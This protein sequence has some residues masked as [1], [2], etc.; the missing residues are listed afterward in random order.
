M[1]SPA[2]RPPSRETARP[3]APPGTPSN[4]I[5]SASVNG[6]A[7][8]SNGDLTCD[9]VSLED[10]AR[11]H[12]TPL[13]VYSAARIDEAY[14]R[15]DAAFAAGPAPRLLR[16]QGQLEPRD[17]PAARLAR[18]RGRR[19]LGRRAPGLPR[20]RLPGRRRSSSP[21]SAR[22]TRSCGSASRAG[23]SPST[24]SPSARS[25]ASTRWPRSHNRTARVALRV[26]PDIDAR[27]HPYIST[28]LKQNKFG[29]D[30]GR[31]R[32]IFERARGLPHLRLVGYPGAHRQPDP[33]RPSRWPRR[34][35]SSRRSPRAFRHRGS[36]RGHRHRRRD[37]HRRTRRRR[38]PTR[39][40]SCRLSTG[41]PVRVLIEPGRAIAGPAGVLVTR[42]LGVK[43]ERGRPSSSSTPG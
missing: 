23:S 24:P 28:G 34:P 26:N 10:L 11:E 9:G 33:R 13:Y 41:L 31:A 22:R 5:S 27:S 35:G 17:P 30:I 6:F 42:V 2:S 43:G 39:Q 8:D 40:P 12:G 37:R 38:R 7:R 14:R 16:G 18:R 29:V 1:P 15:F 19:R 4:R 3:K 32:E 25:S 20:E 21:A 36:D